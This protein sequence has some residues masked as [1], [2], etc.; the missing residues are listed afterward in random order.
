MIPQATVDRILDLTKVEEVIGDFVSLKRRGASYVACCPFHNEK[1]PSFNVTPSKGFYYCFGCHKGGNAVNFLMEH[2]NMGYV[3]ALR[4][5]ASKYHVEI[6]EEEE[7]P[8]AV[9]A[10][11]KREGLFLATD[12]AA[13]FYASCLE[14]GEG[15]SVGYNY[16]R[17]RGMEDE[18]IRRFGLGWSPSDRNALLA[19][20]AAKGYKSDSFVEA[21]VCVRTSDGREYDR[22]HD[23]VIFPIYNDS[24]KVV[25]FGG[26]TLFS[27]FK[28][29]GIGKYVNSPETPIY[30]KKNTLYGLF[31]AKS[32]IAKED[33]CILVEGNIDVISM[34]Q[35][36]LTNT[37]ASCGTALTVEQ[38]RRIKR[39]TNNLTIVYD[40]DSAGIH[41]A[42]RGVS[43]ALREGLDVKV[44]L[45]PDGK[46]PD[47]YCRSH[48]LE[49]VKDYISRN[50]TDFIR[51]KAGLSLEAAADDPLKRAQV[52]NEVADTIALI[53]DPVKR[54]VYTDFCSSLMSI[55][56]N[57][58]MERVDLTKQR[59]AEEEWKRNN[60]ARREAGEE[61]AA[62]KGSE[63]LSVAVSE[64]SSPLEPMERSLLEFLL[65]DGLLEMSFPV[66]HSLYSDPPLTVAE[67]IDSSLSDD[68]LSFSVPEYKATYDAYFRYFDEGLGQD[69]ILRKLVL[70]TD[71]RIPACVAA[72][73]S[74]RHEVTG[75]KL[76]ASITSEQT[77]VLRGVPKAL[78]LYRDKLLEQ[79]EARLREELTRPG[80]DVRELLESI[81]QIGAQRRILQKET[82]RI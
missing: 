27:D 29:R 69:G 14:S 75:E 68:K 76:L 12:F 18:T 47:D 21:G 6:E 51:F 46:D 37:V 80:A 56:R 61:K 4:Y 33:N 3:E 45:L 59:I 53:P 50:A 71:S 15:R 58:V 72:L 64:N 32:S 13:S 81:R 70:E 19:A 9:M 25:G 74:R 77:I 66:G 17:S 60:S 26:R 1:T 54:S 41:A 52:I 55:D 10:R 48:S 49:E 31:Q 34:H 22:F 82:G 2:E 11:Q 38:L 67:F 35:L 39:F 20:A 44:V 36:G 42:D 40:G 7:S 78:L 43:L 57:S 23:R 30:I 16:F 65:K 63:P 24:G 62:G 28:E 5:L 79:Q 8:E 73:T